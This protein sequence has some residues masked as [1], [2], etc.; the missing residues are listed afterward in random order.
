LKLRFPFLGIELTTGRDRGQVYASGDA[1]VILDSA[2]KIAQYLRDGGSTTSGA[3]VNSNT[4]MRVAAVFRCVSL[5]SGAVATMPLQLKRRTNTNTTQSA[6]GEPEASLFTRRPN[7]WM[8][9]SA[10]KRMMTAHVLLRGNAYALKVFNTAGRVRSLI[11]IHPDRVL[12]KQRADLSL[13]YEYTRPA[14]GKIDIPQSDMLHLIGLTLDGVNGVSVIQYAR[15][16]I[17]LSMQTEAHGATVFKNGA[18]VG[19]VLMSKKILG[20][21]AADNLRDSMEKYRGAENAHKTLV[22]E[23]D[24]DFKP[25]GMTAEDAQ[26]I[27]TRKFTR[28]EI[29]MFFGVPPHMIGDTEKATSWGSG[30]EQQAQGFVAYTLEDWLTTWEETGDR[31]ILQADDLF[32]RFNRAALIRGD[33]K[34]RYEAYAK[35]RTGGWLSVNDIRGWEDL[36]PIE[37]GDIYLEPLNMKPAGDSHEPL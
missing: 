33:I 20:Q 32:W 24:M 17:G 7:R 16:A 13:E 4:A 9:A 8:T 11:P 35:G 25:L 19:S 28:S 23:E 22:L 36:N 29:A 15:E 27:E 26:Y 30:I 10:F 18:T 1:G 37:D 5:I 14:G 34:T 2:D 12:V 31:D 6:S 3:N 21:E